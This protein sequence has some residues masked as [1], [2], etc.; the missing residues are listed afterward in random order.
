MA[1]CEGP[2]ARLLFQGRCVSFRRL[3]RNA[4]ASVGQVLAS[5]ALLV[6]LYWLLGRY[7]KPE[8]IGLWSLVLAT[9]AVG[10]L[11]D[12]GFGSAVTL[13][14]ASD[15]GKSDR[16]RAARTIGSGCMFVAG[17]VAI[18]CPVL[19]KLFQFILPRLVPADYLLAALQLLPFALAS[20]AIGTI[21]GI[22]LGALDAFQ[23]TD[24]RALAQIAGSAI[25]FIAAYVFLPS[26][27]FSGL[28]YVQLAQAL[29]LLTLAVVFTKTSLRVPLVHW[30]QRDTERFKG[31]VRY[32]GGLQIAAIGQL[33]F[34][35]CVKSLLAA[36]GGLSL[37][38]YYEIA[39]RMVLQL[40]GIIVSAYNVLV[41]YVAGKLAGAADTSGEV[42]RIYTKSYRLLFA[43]SLP[44]YALAAAALPLVVVA[45]AREMNT[46]LVLVCAL[47]LIGWLLNTLVASAYFLF[48]AL[49][50]VHWTV[51]SQVVIGVLN[52][53]LASVAGYF[54]GGFGV[55]VGSVIALSLGS[56]VVPWAF[57][58]EHRIAFKFLMPSESVPLALASVGCATSALVYAAMSGIQFDLAVGSL[59]L[60][61][62]LV[63]LLVMG[64]IHPLTRE[65][66]GRFQQ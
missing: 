23:R 66:L 45:W 24:L 9:T 4:L 62:S 36:F 42:T 29:G 50:A 33:F 12:F 41:P 63:L 7:L 15:M 2:Y 57:H 11:S 21:S 30:F 65:L 31:L 1:N 35:P 40:R 38:G 32:G 22:F 18:V 54:F 56:F 8:E 25:Q 59:I 52:L 27:G 14:V 20:L 49:G 43:A 13:F 61:A 37:T 55:L 39:N 64:R 10:R 28:G 44:Y 51:V 16:Q 5:T 3:T 58:R 34:D 60:L 17:I 47:C 19:F 53:L 26:R 46:T 48:L 6:G